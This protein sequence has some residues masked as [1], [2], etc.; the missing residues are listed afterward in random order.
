MTLT[1][2]CGTSAQVAMHHTVQIVHRDS[3]STAHCDNY[4]MRLIARCWC[5]CT[6][7]AGIAQ[8]SAPSG[9]ETKSVAAVGASPTRRTPTP[10]HQLP[11]ATHLELSVQLGL[12]GTARPATRTTCCCRV[13]ASLLHAANAVL[14]LPSQARSPP[15]AG[16]ARC[17]CTWWRGLLCWRATWRARLKCWPLRRLCSAL[18]L[19][20]S[21]L[22]R[23]SA[24]QWQR[25]VRC[26]L[27]P[28][29]LNISSQHL[30]LPEHLRKGILS[31]TC[32]V[33][34]NP[35]GY[36]NTLQRLKLL[37]F[38]CKKRRIGTAS[39]NVG[40]IPALQAPSLRPHLL[41]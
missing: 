9:E 12:Q 28:L 27:A 26:D 40:A 17:A 32:P 31:H 11:F 38:T 29:V 36:Q 16:R 3:L 33:A 25:R 35:L 7:D 10:R 15:R 30:C 2:A 39:R 34:F 20:A 41:D 6:A 24:R 1:T 19:S 14:A 21:A 37:T 4:R 22:C 18:T 23:W 13:T 5:L 8:G